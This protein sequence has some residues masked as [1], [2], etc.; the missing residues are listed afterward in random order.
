MSD[1]ATKPADSGSAPAPAVP[2]KYGFSARFAGAIAVLLKLAFGALVG[3]RL[4]SALG[5]EPLARPHE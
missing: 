4:A 3:A 5:W 1:V 2:K